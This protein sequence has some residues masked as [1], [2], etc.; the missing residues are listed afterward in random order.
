MGLSG[1]KC[2]YIDNTYSDELSETKFT[3]KITHVMFR[4]RFCDKPRERNVIAFPDSVT[5]LEL[6]VDY[7]LHFIAFPKNL[8]KLVLYGNSISDIKNIEFPE[9]LANLEWNVKQ[10]FYY[11]GTFW[12]N[13]FLFAKSYQA[14]GIY[15]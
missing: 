2:L 12:G 15:S 1:S 9:S 4:E 11:P 7:N 8:K 5:K 10:N 6:N 14:T 3:K 13:S